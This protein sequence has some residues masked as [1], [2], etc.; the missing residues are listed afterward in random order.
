[1]LKNPE[2]D[3]IMNRSVLRI[4]HPR[5][6]TVAVAAVFCIVLSVNL[7][8]NDIQV[9][10]YSLYAATPT[11]AQRDLLAVTRTVR[12]PEGTQTLGEAVRY[13]LKGSGYRLPQTESIGPDAMGLFALPL[14]TV[15]QQM[16]PM[17]LRAALETLAGPAFNLVQ[18]PVHRLITY[19]RCALDG[20]DDLKVVRRTVE[21]GEKDE[22]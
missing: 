8:A 10:R 18:D 9:G 12:F 15:H 14:P 7:Q 20:F 3:F 5:I 13:L 16:G 11:Q 1:M 2:A 4:M 17:T 21:E 22:D 19:E 6:A